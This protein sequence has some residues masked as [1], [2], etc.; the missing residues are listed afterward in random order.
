MM[1]Y[2]D[3]DIRNDDYDLDRDDCDNDRD[4]RAPDDV[5]RRD[6][7]DS[8]NDWLRRSRSTW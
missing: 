8:I 3:D 6:N 1:E 5:I 7:A 2:S 4:E